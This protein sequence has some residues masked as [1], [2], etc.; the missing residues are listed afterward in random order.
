[1]D[2]PCAELLVRAITETLALS[3]INELYYRC[4]ERQSALS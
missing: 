2:A 3:I 1:M 4:M